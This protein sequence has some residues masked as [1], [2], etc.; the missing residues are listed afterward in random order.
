M[1]VDFFYGFTVQGDIYRMT[2]KRKKGLLSQNG[3]VVLCSNSKLINRV[4]SKHIIDSTCRYNLELK[5]TKDICY[6][7]GV[8]NSMF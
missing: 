5:Q 3:F 1:S 2:Q 8:L 6:M 7:L 4:N